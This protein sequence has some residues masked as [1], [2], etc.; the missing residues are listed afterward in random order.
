MHTLPENEWDNEI[1]NYLDHMQDF[2]YGTSNTRYDSVPY[3]LWKQ[4]LYQYRAPIYN[5]LYPTYNEPLQFPQFGLNPQVSKEASSWG[6]TLTNLLTTYGI[7]SMMTAVPS[8]VW[9]GGLAALSASYLTSKGLELYDYFKNKRT[10]PMVNAG[11][12]VTSEYYST[13]DEDK[14]PT[15]ISLNPSD[16]TTKSRIRSLM[17]KRA[18]QMLVPKVEPEVIYYPTDAATKQKINKLSKASLY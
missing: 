3:P 2:Y 15:N 5:R 1:E 13:N 12:D 4:K 16:E 14:H 6:S 10:K 7:K 18:S 8:W 17:N 9:R 11:V